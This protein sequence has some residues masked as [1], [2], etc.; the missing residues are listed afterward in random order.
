MKSIY[1]S[2]LLNDYKIRVFNQTDPALGDPNRPALGN[3]IGSGL[4]YAPDRSRHP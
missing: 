3:P 4:G 1:G 2:D